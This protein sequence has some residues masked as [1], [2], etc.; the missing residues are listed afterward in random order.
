MRKRPASIPIPA[1]QRLNERRTRV[2]PLLVFGAA[3][4]VA[5]MLWRDA[6]TPA[7]LTGE[8]VTVRSS[9]RTPVAATIQRVSAQRLQMVK[10]GDLIAE[11]RATDPRQTMDFIQSEL[12][13]LRL[14]T[15]A[16]SP[17]A[18]S[19]RELLDFERLRLDWMTQKVELAKAKADARK[20][21]ME[22][23]AAE[24]L[25]SAAG[26]SKRFVEEARVAKET[27][28][29]EVAARQEL[30]DSLGRRMEA[31]GTAASA[32]APARDEGL[33]RAVT[34]IEERLRSI[35]QN[36]SV[37]TLRAPMDGMVSEVLRRDGEN[38]AAG[39]PLLVITA[40]AAER[41]VGY[42]RQPFPLEPAVGMEVEVRTRGRD[43][44]S[45][46]AAITRVGVHFEAILNPALHPA[47]T[48][49]VGLPVE[50]SLPPDLRL[51]PGELVT[52]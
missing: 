34:G 11:L 31:L 41:I 12:S 42:L 16:A 18:S 19:R 46:L 4:F 35:E 26:A 9:V 43:R 48:P 32:G 52:W 50:V 2:A 33:A 25:S 38:V 47:P 21:A 1:R 24:G 17:A 22:L 45:G 44:R 5:V 10:A 14:E 36:H 29:A 15:E 40:A 51:R 39:E 7:M 37:I 6:F 27:S 13:L 23:E 28:D 8:V 30:V 20:T 3:A 49:E